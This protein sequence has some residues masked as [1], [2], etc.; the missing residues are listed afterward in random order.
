M[1]V[2]LVFNE[3]DIER[4][5]RFYLNHNGDLSAAPINPSSIEFDYPDRRNTWGNVK[6]QITIS[7][8][9]LASFN[10]EY[11]DV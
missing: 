5:I 6:A 2:V 4:A 7:P 1:K 11:P 3:A 9:S 8:P 10:Y